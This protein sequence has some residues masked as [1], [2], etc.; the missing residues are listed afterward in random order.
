MSWILFALIAPTLWAIV[1][2]SDKFALSK[3]IDGKRPQ[4][5]MLFEVI[6]A[7]LIVGSIFFFLSTDV[8]FHLVYGTYGLLNG[9]FGLTAILFYYFAMRFAD[10]SAIVPLFQFIPL[11]LAPLGFFVFGE[12]LSMSEG[13]AA[14]FLVVGGYVVS[15]R[16]IGDIH[17]L[18]KRSLILM[19]V[20]SFLMALA[21]IF[22]KL[23]AEHYAYWDV[24]F[25]GRLA[26][27]FLPLLFLFSPT[28][29]RELFDLART[30]SFPWFSFLA[31]RSFVALCA[32]A[33]FLYAVTIAPVVLVQAISGVQPIIALVIGLTLFWYRPKWFDEKFDAGNLLLKVSGTV[34]V[35]LGLLLLLFW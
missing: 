5:L 6:F 2:Y 31:F 3:L 26:T 9:L 10:P 25:Y 4:T 30:I 11:F 20:A 29:R 16:K 23:A 14:V 22:F 12:T 18:D 21:S 8:T 28:I 24:V 32:A 1:N 19:I 27:I 15:L 33:T 17:V 7:V 35:S 13:F 34:A